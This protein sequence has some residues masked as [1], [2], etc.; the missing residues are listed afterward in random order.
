[1][2]PVAANARGNGSIQTLA[3]LQDNLTR[4]GFLLL[5][6]ALV[7][8]PHVPPAIEARAWLPFLQTVLA[9]L[10]GTGAK[11]VLWGKIAEQL[12]KLPEC[13]AL[14]AAVLRASL[15]PVIHHACGHAGTVRPDGVAARAAGEAL[16]AEPSR[17]RLPVLG[18]SKTKAPDLLYLT[19][20]F[21]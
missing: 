8:R 15:Q 3:Q 1:M 11:L 9:A 12:K 21:N 17:R 10:A 14:R 7:F 4:H 20:S 19:K 13:A 18:R 6:A 2:A 5:N 16:T